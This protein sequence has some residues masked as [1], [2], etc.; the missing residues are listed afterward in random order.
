MI[1]LI[2]DTEDGAYVQLSSPYIVKSTED[3]WIAFF[4]EHGIDEGQSFDL[5]EYRTF[6]KEGMSPD[7]WLNYI[8]R[9]CL[10]ISD[11]SVILEGTPLVALKA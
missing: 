4:A 11:M 8:D 7:F 5:E 2:E 3:E 1:R 9:A 6:M 10:S